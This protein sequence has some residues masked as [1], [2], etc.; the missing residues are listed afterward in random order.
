MA[1]RGQLL[2]L[3][4]RRLY[5][6]RQADY[7]PGRCGVL[8][9][10]GSLLSGRDLKK[11]LSSNVKQTAN[12][13]RFISSVIFSVS[14]LQTRYG[15][16]Y[17]FTVVSRPG[18]DWVCHLW[19]AAPGTPTESPTASSCPSTDVSALNAH[20]SPCFLSQSGFSAAVSLAALSSTG[21]GAEALQKG[22]RKGQPR[23]F[24]GLTSPCHYSLA[25]LKCKGLSSLS[26]GGGCL[27][28]HQS[29][30]STWELSRG[31]AASA[32]GNP[33]L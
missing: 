21:L 14:F 29:C 28:T 12:S 30:H 2:A 15:Q 1:P 33:G 23:V 32:G 16:Q 13:F 7:L 11:S 3:S 27:G 6:Q 22:L 9:V 17:G 18:P 20:N 25:P 31:V 26:G 5:L 24:S 4:E 8:A 10:P 19:E